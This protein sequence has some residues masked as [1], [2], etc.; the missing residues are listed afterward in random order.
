MSI[1]KRSNFYDCVSFIHLVGIMAFLAS[2]VSWVEYC[3]RK[4]KIY[5]WFKDREIRNIKNKVIV[6]RKFKQEIDSSYQVPVNSANNHRTFA[7][8]TE[9]VI[10]CI[11]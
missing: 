7:S 2:L 8:N 1:Y 10:V 6:E 11:K 3:L 5:T 9:R 4:R